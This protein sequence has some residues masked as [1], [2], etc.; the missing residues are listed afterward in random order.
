MMEQENNYTTVDLLKLVEG[1]VRRAWVIA[2]SMLLCGVIAFSSAAF[3]ITPLYESRIMFYVNNTSFSMGS[4][5]FSIST[6]EISAAKSLV[7]TYLVILKTRSTLRDVITV[8]GI[9]RTYGE[10]K[11]MIEADSVNNTEI[12]S[13]NVTSDDPREAEHIA[14]TIGQ[15]LP[16]KIASVVDGS[17][18]RIVDYAVVPGAKKSPNITRYTILGMLIGL[19]LSCG[20]IVLIEMMDDQIRSEDYLIQ[21]YSNI[22]L[23]TAIPDMLDDRGTGYYYYRRYGYG[24]RQAPSEA[25]PQQTR[26]KTNQG[27]AEKPASKNTSVKKG[28]K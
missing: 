26:G 17:S 6:N 10:L 16:D 25:K 9:D 18:V 19:V 15:V 12:F 24:Y 2:L 13:V 8:G 1:L 27:N 28:G 3:F 5:N 7:N 22:P 4:T 20:I 23:L 21:N 11:Q 14:N